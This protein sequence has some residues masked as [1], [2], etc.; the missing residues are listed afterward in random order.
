MT[1]RYARLRLLL[2]LALVLIVPAAAANA[3]VSVTSLGTAVTQNFDPLAPS[4]TSSVVPIRFH[5]PVT[6]N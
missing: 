6:A 3:Q 5:Y 1:Q 4:G 2:I